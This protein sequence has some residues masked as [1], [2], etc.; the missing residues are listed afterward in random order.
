MS[1]CLVRMFGGE[2]PRVPDT[3]TK[4]TCVRVFQ[5]LSLQLQL[6]T[7]STAPWTPG[8]K[9]WT[10]KVARSLFFPQTTKSNSWT[11]LL[12]YIYIITH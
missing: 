2:I 1:E 8:E 12:K 7:A 10:A 5:L 9:S 6:F 11:Q 4:D 3:V